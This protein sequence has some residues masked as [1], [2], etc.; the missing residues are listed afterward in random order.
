MTAEASLFSLLTNEKKERKCHSE[1][2][3]E[4]VDVQFITE[5]RAEFTAAI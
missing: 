1:N 4:R 2:D 3:A 5:T